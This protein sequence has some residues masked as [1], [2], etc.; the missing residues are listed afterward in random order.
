MKKI[1]VLTLF[2]VTATFSYAEGQ[3]GMGLFIFGVYFSVALTFTF[4]IGSIV[5][6]VKGVMGYASEPY[7]V[8]LVYFFTFSLTVLF[9][10]L[11][12]T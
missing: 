1:I 9:Y 2:L 4:M 5:L 3:A 8:F 10:V 7:Q 6:I 11:L 12:N